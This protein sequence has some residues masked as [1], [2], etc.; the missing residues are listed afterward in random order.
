MFCPILIL[1][2]SIP[3]SFDIYTSSHFYIYIN[4]FGFLI[5]LH[6]NSNFFLFVL[7]Q[8]FLSLLNIM[9]KFKKYIYYYNYSKKTKFILEIIQKFLLYVYISNIH[10]FYSLCYKIVK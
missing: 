1:S 8:Y 5:L 10:I 4:I 9:I 3:K 7:S 2:K 6:I